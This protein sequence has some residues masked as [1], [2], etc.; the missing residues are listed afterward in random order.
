MRLFSGSLKNSTFQMTAFI[1]LDYTHDQSIVTDSAIRLRW[2]NTQHE[3]HFYG[4]ATLAAAHVLF[5]SSEQLG[6]NTHEIAFTMLAGQLKARKVG[7]EVELKFPAGEV[8][9][10]DDIYEGGISLR[11]SVVRA[12]RLKGKESIKAVGEGGGGDSFKGFMVVGVD[13]ATQI[14]D[15]KLDVKSFVRAKIRQPY[16]IAH[17]LFL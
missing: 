8:L 15:M 7:S 1:H 4:H 2:F 10:V 17:Y 16:E 3:Y 13:R 6:A 11:D 5:S 9:L 14:K 12:A